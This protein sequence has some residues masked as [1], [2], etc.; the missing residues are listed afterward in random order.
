[1]LS[2]AS[3]LISTAAYCPGIQTLPDPSIT[4]EA[5]LRAQQRLQ[6][7]A[8]A[9][10]APN[11]A[12]TR[13]ASAIEIDLFLAGGG[14][15]RASSEEATLELE[16]SLLSLCEETG[17]PWSRALWPRLL[18]DR[19]RAWQEHDCQPTLRIES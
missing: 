1:M 6:S 2:S 16:Q 3:A 18:R 8:S 5:L 7:K 11:S 14:A 15:F 19:R 12:S 10:E 4:P 9:V 17:Y 13:W